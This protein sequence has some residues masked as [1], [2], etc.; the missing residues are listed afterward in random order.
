MRQCNVLVNSVEERI[1]L[2]NS[3][4]SCGKENHF[5]KCCQSTHRSKM[6]AIREE[7]KE[8]SSDSDYINCV[9]L[10]Q[11]DRASCCTHR[12]GQQCSHHDETLWRSKDLY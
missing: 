8:I 5:A 12:L 6:H 11:P 10:A 2:A 7:Y 4:T 9:T 1:D 3:S